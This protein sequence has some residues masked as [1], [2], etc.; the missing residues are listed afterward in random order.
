[1]FRLDPVNVEGKTVAGAAV[2]SFFFASFSIASLS[3]LKAVG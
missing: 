1:M 2:M 3:V